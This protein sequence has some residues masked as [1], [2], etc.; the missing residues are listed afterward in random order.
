MLEILLRT[1]MYSFLDFRPS[2][3]LGRAS[4]QNVACTLHCEGGEL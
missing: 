3:P 4:V 1:E 2:V